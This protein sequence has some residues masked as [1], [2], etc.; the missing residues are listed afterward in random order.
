LQPPGL[1][2]AA[3]R[4]LA[5]TQYRRMVEF[6]SLTF[7]QDIDVRPGAHLSGCDKAMS[8]PSCFCDLSGDVLNC[9]LVHSSSEAFFVGS[10]AL[11]SRF[12]ASRK[13]FGDK[14]PRDIG[15][16]GVVF[17]GDFV[18]HSNYSFGHPECEIGVVTSSRSAALFFRL[19]S[20]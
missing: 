11:A 18:N 20:H 16:C 17:F 12:L 19:L 3:A 13:C 15:A 4:E 10:G 6:S 2:A 9:V 8:L 7:A 14:L 5:G 1:T